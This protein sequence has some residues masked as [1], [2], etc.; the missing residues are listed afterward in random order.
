MLHELFLALSGHPSPLLSKEPLPESLSSSLSPSE[1]ALLRS[2]AHLGNL[3]TRVREQCS[4]ISS[5]HDS[6]ICRAVSTAIANTHLAQFQKK[7]VLVERDVLLQDASLVGAYQVVPLSAVAGAFDGWGQRLEWLQMLLTF[8]LNANVEEGSGSTKGLRSGIGPATGAA[9]MDKLRS[10]A[11]TG[12]PSIER[13]A[14][15]LAKVAE[16][17][18]LRQVSTWIL[19]GRL[20]TL[21]A[22]DFFVQHLSDQ[23]TD[24]TSGAWEFRSA[25][26]PQFLTTATAHSIFFIGKSINH[27][28]SKDSTALI[29][30]RQQASKAS[31][32]TP[33]SSNSPETSLITNHLELL[34]SLSY[35]ISSTALTRTISAIR[36]S[37]SIDAL[38]KLLSLAEILQVLRVFREF[39]LLQRGEFAIALI[40]AADSCLASKSQKSAYTVNS[41]NVRLSGAMIRETDVAAT[42]NQAW[43]TLASLQGIDDDEDQE[44]ELARDLV[45]MTVKKVHSKKTPVAASLPTFVT[46]VQPKLSDLFG[47]LLLAT[48]IVLDLQITSPLDLFLTPNDIEMYSHI[49]A[50]LLSI[51]RAQSHLSGLWKLKSLRKESATSKLLQTQMRDP[52]KKSARAEE[53][54]RQRS[55][56]MRKTWTVVGL[57][58]SFLVELGEYFH[59]EV[60]SRS[61][62][63]FESWLHPPP[64]HVRS[65]NEVFGIRLDQQSSAGEQPADPAMTSQ[66]VHDPETI[67]LAHRVFLSTLSHALLLDDG[68]FAQL[69]RALLTRVDYLVGLMGRLSDLRLVSETRDS[70]TASLQTSEEDE[71]T[72]NIDAACTSIG[73]DIEALKI[74]LRELDMER[75]GEN[76]EAVRMEEGEM[77]FVPWQAAALDRLLLKVDSGSLDG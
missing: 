23:G 75:L 30:S 5:T 27:V 72:S 70:R 63:T 11:Q 45:C 22:C 57:V 41:D 59:G 56:R 77:P 60:V 31:S 68:G 58:T 1:S 55:R 2:I 24:S 69:L 65:S 61:W 52:E 71:L 53:S 54:R 47:D 66:P 7:I 32:E 39:F 26:C 21:G 43:A 3:H 35:P 19:Y 9:V 14:H 42:L 62:T 40:N 76:L 6:V 46:G 34:A 4:I 38:Q 37:L 64:P 50:F 18:W 10:E 74:R 67:T 49:H 48:P 16:L 44:L 51:R 15:D 20:P 28:R 73:R 25:L 36:N 13:I 8:I 17:A 29:L 33:S 12:Y